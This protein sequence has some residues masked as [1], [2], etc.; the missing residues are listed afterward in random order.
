[1]KD[2]KDKA[3]IQAYLTEFPSGEN[4][5][6]AKTILKKLEA[7][8]TSVP[9]TI[10]ANNSS[11]AVKAGAVKRNSIGM[12]LVYIPAGDFLMGSTKAEIDQAWNE[13]KKDDAKCRRDYFTSVSPKHKVSIK[14]GF[15]MGKYEVTQAEWQAVMGDNPSEFK[16]FGG[17]CPVEQVSWD[18]IQIFLKK[19]N[20][21]NDGFEYSLPSEAQWEYAARGGTTTFS[22]GDRLNATQ[23]NF[24]ESYAYATRK[25]T[26]INKTVKVGSYQPN[27]FGLY[28]MYG[29]VYEWTQDIYNSNDANLPPDSSIDLSVGKLNVLRGGAWNEDGR[30]LLSA[31]RVPSAP[32]NRNYNVG[33]RVVARAR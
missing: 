14:D 24:T 22:F 30:N 20:A 12:D 8:A 33:F 4:V 29:N 15:W 5:F 10:A 7:T 3:K 17:N 28:D 16:D 32:S 13:C 26:S 6:A 27:N 9:P 18:D 21:K 2:S 1:M 11:S 23:A 31:N 25:G 19:L